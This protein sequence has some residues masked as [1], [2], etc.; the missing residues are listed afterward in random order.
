MIGNRRQAC[1][2]AVQLQRTIHT[3]G[4]AQ[5]TK[6]N[7]A[8]IFQLQGFG[9]LRVGLDHL[10]EGTDNVRRGV[11][12]PDQLR[13]HGADGRLGVAP[14]TRIDNARDDLGVRLVANFVNNFGGNHATGGRR[15]VVVVIVVVLLLARMAR[16]MM[17]RLQIVERMSHIPFGRE[18]NGLQ[19]RF[20]IRDIFGPTHAQQTFEHLFVTEPRI[21]QNGRPRLNGFDNFGRNVAR[22]TKA[23]RG[24]KHFH[25]PSQ[26]LLCGSR[27]AIGLVQDNNLVSTGR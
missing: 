17:R 25:G 2:Q 7:F 19:A 16:Q 8:Q 10:E 26:G 9:E 11:A 1:Q 27:H 14:S 24:T 23:R 15:L 21:A 18:Q 22:Q 4:N 6:A 3:V 13:L 20:R 5:M 12:Q